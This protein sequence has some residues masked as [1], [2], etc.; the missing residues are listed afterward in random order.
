MV[1]SKSQEKINVKNPLGMNV[2]FLTEVFGAEHLESVLDLADL[3]SKGATLKS[4]KGITDE[5]MEML[6]AHAYQLY[7]TG[8]YEKASGIF[9]M[10]VMHDHWE[11]KYFLGLGATL[12]MLKL[13]EKA[14]EVYS[15]CFLLDR[16]NPVAPFQA[17][18]CY[19]ALN[20]CEKAKSA[21]LS[22]DLFCSDDPQFQVYRTQAVALRERL[23][24]L[25]KTKAKK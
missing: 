13:Y 7:Q 9:R 20:D 25:E 17:G 12:Q 23:I 6:Y 4:I 18:K 1:A 22:V 11:S 21:F 3:L 2:E 8:C 10:L 24:A 15:Y 16:K 5:Q 14:A 19:M